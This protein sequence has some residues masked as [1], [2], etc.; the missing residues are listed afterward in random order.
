MVCLSLSLV[1]RYFY[2]TVYPACPYSSLFGLH[3]YKRVSA[4]R[5]FRR[6]TCAWS[7]CVLRG[8]IPSP[9]PKYVSK[10]TRHRLLRLAVSSPPPLPLL[11]YRVPSH[12]IP[13][14]PVPSH[15]PDRLPAAPAQ[16]RPGGPH[17]RGQDLRRGP[18]V[19]GRDDEGPVRQLPVPEDSGPRGRGCQDQP[20]HTGAFSQVSPAWT[21]LASCLAMRC[22]AMRSNSWCGDRRR[23]F[24]VSLV[25][26]FTSY[27]KVVTLWCGAI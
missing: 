21:W 5:F 9:N 16:A 23:E 8:W 12:P 3:T 15:N 14:R 18:A 25:G 7:P 22:A 27:G 13:S 11:S 1:N 24:G 2:K 17:V 4:V 20:R 26:A 6:Q 19:P 10:L